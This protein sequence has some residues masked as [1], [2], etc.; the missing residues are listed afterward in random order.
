[1]KHLY[2]TLSF[3]LFV[4]H[5]V[6]QN[7]ELVFSDTCYYNKNYKVIYNHYETPNSYTFL[8]VKYYT[9]DG[10]YQFLVPWRS[11]KFNCV[12]IDTLSVIFNNSCG[13]GCRENVVCIPGRKAQVYTDVFKTNYKHQLI[14]TFY[15]AKLCVIDYLINDTIFC[16]QIV[17]IDV[18]K[19]YYHWLNYYEPIKDIKL[20]SDRV[21][22]FVNKKYKRAIVPEF[23]NRKVITLYYR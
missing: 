3:L 22:L 12:F 21:I 17:D 16:K 18:L 11:A 23:R 13:T 15:L 7:I 6:A 9:P 5:I 14:A 10:K 20:L 19:N 2:L 1:M 4:F 8:K